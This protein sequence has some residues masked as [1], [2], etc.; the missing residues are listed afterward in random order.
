MVVFE[1]L[2]RV[3]I[4]LTSGANGFLLIEFLDFAIAELHFLSLLPI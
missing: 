3:V 2:W 4:R 1:Y